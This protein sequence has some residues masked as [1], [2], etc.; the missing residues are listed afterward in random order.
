MLRTDAKESYETLLKN[1]VYRNTFQPIGPYGHRTVSIVTR[2][3][4][5]GE[6][7][8]YDLPIFTRDISIIE[9]KIP[10]K[11]ELKADTSYL[12]PEKVMNGGIYLFRNLSIY[13]N[14]IKQIQG[15]MNCF[16]YQDYFH[17]YYYR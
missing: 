7:H 9:P 17:L 4:C 5:L 12:V 2:V 1:L 8:A 11:I 16:L 13:T 6:V 15:K 3:K 10:T 14:T